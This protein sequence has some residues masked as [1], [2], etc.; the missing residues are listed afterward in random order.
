[1]G[2][3]LKAQMARNAPVRAREL[4]NP[5]SEAVAPYALSLLCHHLVYSSRVY[6]CHFV[7]DHGGLVQ[8]VSEK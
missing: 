1:M 7:S 4:A 3:A 8:V 2:D 6:P 5:V